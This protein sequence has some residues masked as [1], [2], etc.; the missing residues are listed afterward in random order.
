MYV[1]LSLQAEE[2]LAFVRH[3]VGVIPLLLFYLV[4][5]VLPAFL[6]TMLRGSYDV[7]RVLAREHVV[8]DSREVPE[9][10]TRRR[11]PPTSLE[12]LHILRVV[13]SV[14]ACA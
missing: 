10:A 9:R 4:V 11:L 5:D 8:R 6:F 2:I 12:P 13:T 7:V 3:V 1:V 14:K